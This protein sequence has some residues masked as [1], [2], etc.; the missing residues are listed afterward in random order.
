MREIRASGALI[1]CAAA[2]IVGSFQLGSSVAAP[3]LPSTLTYQGRLTD[4]NGKPLEG[5][6]P[7][8]T[9]RIFSAAAPLDSSTFVWGEIHE[10]VHVRRGVFSVQL[11]AGD[12]AIDLNGALSPG[13]NPVGASQL[14]GSPRWVQVEVDGEPPLSPATPLS[15]VPYAIAAGSVVEGGS[16]SMPV[17]GIMPWWPPTPGAQPPP[18]FEYCDGTAVTTP[19]SAYLG[20]NKPNLM[21]PSRMPRGLSASLL[22]SHGGASGF[23]TGGADSVGNHS[24]SMGSHTH[25]ILVDGNHSHQVVGST[26]AN[27][28]TY[29]GAGVDD[30]RAIVVTLNHQHNFN[31]TSQSGG[32]HNHGGATQSAGGGGTSSA[33]AHS[34]LPGFVS[35]VY[36]VR[37]K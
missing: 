23:P 36:V 5:V 20:I 17:G 31:V 10:D 21:N 16:G 35:F 4:S 30:F 28:Q 1:A 22:A 6:L 29:T 14:D 18:G 19:G 33:G 9:F 27:T 24:H 3:P 32:A 11:G 15:S 13:P 2:L 8:V 37:V 25:G 12:F 34:N 7:K 26:S